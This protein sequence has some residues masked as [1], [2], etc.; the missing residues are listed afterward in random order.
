MCGGLV[1]ANFTAIILP[2]DMSLGSCAGLAELTLVFPVH[3]STNL[4][5]V[6][7]LLMTLDATSLRTLT[8]DIRLLGSIDALDWDGLN[9]ILSS[10]SYRSLETI[11]FKVNVWP[12]VHKNLSEVEGIVR[13][14]LS[15]FDKKGMVHVS[16]A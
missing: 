11:M 15:A 5:W 8:C 9:A 3:F 4:P 1:Y 13:A 7:S 12:G 2:D 14:R 16:K 6:T 10:E